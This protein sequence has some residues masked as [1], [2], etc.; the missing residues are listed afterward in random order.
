MGKRILVVVDMQ[1]DF[2]NGSLGTKEAVDIVPNV[3]AKIHSYK[4]D[5]V[6]ATL[7]TH[8]ENYLDTSEGKKL[9]VPHCIKGTDGHQIAPAIAQALSQCPDFT[10]LEKPTFG[11]ID[12]MEHIRNIMEKETVDSIEL[13]GLC[14]DICV[15]SNTLL[16]K[17]QC[18]E[19]HI[20]VDASCCA[21][22]SPA[23]H[24]A[25]L[26]TMSMCQIEILNS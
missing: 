9:P 26:T 12:L 18:P 24:Q 25:A 15:V 21:G 10:C 19:T 2:I 6:F 20:Q 5:T 17:A 7:D 8:P 11:S 23:T 3:I 16:L 14:T 13:C 22:V 4:E 1:N